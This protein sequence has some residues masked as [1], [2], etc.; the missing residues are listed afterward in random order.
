MAELVH[1][2]WR[3]V[4]IRQP[5]G[6]WEWTA[7]R[8][9]NGYGKFWDGVKLTSAHRAAYRIFLGEIPD[10]QNVLHRCDNPSCVNPL[11]LFLGTQ[12]ENVQDMLRKGR[13]AVGSKNGFAKLT[14]AD[15]PMIRSQ[16]RGGESLTSIAKS[17]GVDHATIKDIKLGRTWKHV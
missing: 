3:K 12:S 9:Y 13:A 11:H 17:L 16:L 5:D 15:I 4:A 6:C 14:E 2:F 8:A 1:R 7:C 10:G